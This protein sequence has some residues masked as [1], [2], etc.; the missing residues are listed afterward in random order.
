MI[1]NIQLNYMLNTL[2]CVSN[3][4]SNAVLPDFLSF[5]FVLS[6]ENDN[7]NNMQFSNLIHNKNQRKS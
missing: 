6:S 4:I 1:I 7:D 2:Q 3:I 5:A